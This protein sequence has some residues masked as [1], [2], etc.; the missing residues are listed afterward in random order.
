MLKNFTEFS[1]E[2]GMACLYNNC[3]TNLK[4]NLAHIFAAA[5]SRPLASFELIEMYSKF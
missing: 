2:G 4:S 1:T 5:A 3:L